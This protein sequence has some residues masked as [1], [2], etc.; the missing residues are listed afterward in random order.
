MSWLK[1]S[2]IAGLAG[3]R[4]Q[5]PDVSID[6]VST[7]S[8]TVKE[9][10]L[11][12][13]LRGE[14]FDGHQFVGQGG[15]SAA[16]VSQHCAAKISQIIVAD[17]LAA[18]GRLAR[19]WRQRLASPVIGLT[20][21]NGKTTVK[22]MLYSILSRRGQTLAT[23]GNLNNHIG[24]P[25]TLLRMRSDHRH[26]VIEMGANHPGEIA[27]LT[28]IAMPDVGLVTNAGPAHLE[29]FGNLQGVVKA[30]GELFRG[31]KPEAIAV[32]NADDQACKAWSAM[33]FGRKVVRFG[34]SPLA[35]VRGLQYQGGTLTLRSPL[36][37][38]C[39]S[40]P[41]AGR[42]NAVN[43]LGAAAA[44][45][46]LGVDLADIKAGLEAM[47]PVKGRLAS[48]RAY[49]GARLIDDSYN[50]N[51]GSM[52]AAI[53]YL[54]AQPGRRWLVIGDMGE[55]GIEGGKLHADM[56][57]LAKER[58]LDRL[59]AYGKL[60]AAAAEAFGVHS[61]HFDSIEALSHSLREELEPDVIVLVKGSRSMRLERLVEALR[62]EAPETMS[63][64]CGH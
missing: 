18:L 25:L 23:Q 22:E 62:D 58:G 48:K 47:Q 56:G 12:I 32:I 10:H 50:A 9:G 45:L 37:E 52:S 20:G 6:A 41:L 39:V 42:H 34:F 19:G 30:K 33:A 36:G 44:S 46:A 24:V 4:L 8:R 27:Y 7:D 57:K 38:L 16:M 60:S 2:E 14:R 54:A 35:D 64:A 29:G 51:P 53:E 40:L 59:Y 21:S 11:F 15:M 31:L 3:G 28:D 61:F 17:T 26:S 1:L 13:A 63:A 5:G 49:G 43:A 55:L